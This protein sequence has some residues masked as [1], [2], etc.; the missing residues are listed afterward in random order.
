[1]LFSHPE[2]ASFMSQ[3]FECAWES[4]RPVPR[5][6]ID[7]GNGRTLDRTL[8][9]NVV[10]YLCTPEGEVLDL[11]PGLVDAP[12][13]VRRLDQASRLLRAMAW[14]HLLP[15][16]EPRP[17]LTDSAAAPATHAITGGRVLALRWHEARAAQARLDRARADDPIPLFDGSKMRVERRI[18]LA[19]APPPADAASLSADT[20]ENR[21]HRYPLASQLWLERPFARPADITKAVYRRVLD[22]D[23][24]DPY[25]GLAPDVLGGEGG[26]G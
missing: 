2:V 17:T 23:L 11:V 18:D 7:F 25:L 19:L 24:D 1:V 6:S 13:Y 4:V 20:L 15:L 8:H 12:E 21:V 5:V 16:P 3:A 22:V 9:G 10:T 26:R 14:Q